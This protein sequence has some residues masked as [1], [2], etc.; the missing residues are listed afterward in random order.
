MSFPRADETIRQACRR[1][2][3]APLR[4]EGDVVVGEVAE[5]AVGV[6]QAGKPA[7]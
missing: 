6:S 3:M 5:I 2:R 4:R 1:Q 7:R